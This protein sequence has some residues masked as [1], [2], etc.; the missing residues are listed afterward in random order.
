[1]KDLW[2][3]GPAYTWKCKCGVRLIAGDAAEMER[4]KGEQRDK[5]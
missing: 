3:R 1:M 2:S 5:R 4:Q